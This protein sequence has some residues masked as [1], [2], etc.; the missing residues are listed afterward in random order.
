VSDEKLPGL[1]DT[2]AASGRQSQILKVKL[3]DVGFNLARSGLRVAESLLG[4]ASQ[5]LCE[6]YLRQSPPRA[7]GFHVQFAGEISVFRKE[8]VK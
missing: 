4:A 8:L 6:G 7:N 3:L 1:L 2:N 5:V